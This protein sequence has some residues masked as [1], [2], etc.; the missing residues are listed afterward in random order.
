MTKGLRVVWRYHTLYLMLLP[1][2]VYYAVYRYGPMWGAVIAFKDFNI[3]DGI[4]DSPWADP[5]YKHFAYFYDSP[6]FGQILLNTFLISLYKIVWGMPPGIL[7]ALLL[8]EVRNARFK[9]WIQTVSYLPHFL[10]WVIIY[11]MIFAFLSETGGIVNRWIKDYIGHSIPFLQS[12]DWFRTIL[13]G[14]EVWQTAG[15]SA[16]IYLAALAGV[17]PTL[18]E[19][20]RCDGAGRLRM[21][22]HISLPGIRSVIVL[23]LILKLGHILDAGF[24]QIYI[25]Y[26][27][28]V[29]PVSDIIDTW[30]FRVGLEQLNFSLGAAVGL[31]K[32][33]IGLAL[34]VSANRIARK[35]GEGVW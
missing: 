3:M 10:S 28:H 9:K 32:S 8:Y 6:Y 1:G 18:Y 4:W 17:D 19:A 13:V 34:V 30:V 26:N 12:T 35:W 5:W 14:S 11:G 7:L 31:F 20:A 16:I 22:W 23:L 21:L 24:D 2:L 25:M 27:V 33:L 29:Y 15:W